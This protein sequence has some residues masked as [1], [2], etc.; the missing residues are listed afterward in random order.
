[1]TRIAEGVFWVGA[2]DWTRRDF[3][4]YTTR[5]GTTYNSY[6]ILDEKKALID[7]VQSSHLPELLAHARELVDLAEID[8]LVSLHVEPD[9]SGSLS[10]VLAL[11]P[12]AQLVTVERHGEQ[13]LQKYYQQKLPLMTVKEGSTLSLGKRSLSFFPTPMLHWPDNMLAFLS[14]DAILFSSD[15][16]GQHLASSGRFDDQ[17]DMS[18]VMD[19]AAKYYANIIL[20][21][22]TQVAR[23]LEKTRALNPKVIAPAHGVMWRG[24]IPQILD[25]Y[26]RWSRGET[27]PRAMVVYDTMW[28]STEAMALAVVEGIENEGV[29]VSLHSLATSDSSD[30]VAELLETRALAVGCPILNNNLLPRMAGFLAYLK[31]LRPR[32]RIGAAFGSFGWGG[33]TAVKAIKEDLTLA[34]LE[35]L[36]DELAVRFAPTQEELQACRLLGQKLAQRVKG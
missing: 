22:P 28:H 25:A 6:L 13:G 14:P 32:G 24:H 17:A 8:Y 4:G 3:H 27:R 1:M 9:H 34:G 21:F 18:V 35:V 29:E 5:R 7:T 20:P 16:F 31:G 15:A 12:R 33:A 2:T 30:I 36:E 11:C 19:E 26:G 23:A 10:Q